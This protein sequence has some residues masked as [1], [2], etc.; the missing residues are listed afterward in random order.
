MIVGSH[1]YL[2]VSI[3]IQTDID[4]GLRIGLQITPAVYRCICHVDICTH[5]TVR[6]NHLVVL[7]IF[8]QGE[9]PSLHTLRVL[10]HLRL[11]AHRLFIG[12]IDKQ[13]DDLRF[14]VTD[15]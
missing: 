13:S 11:I 7:S 10:Q 15:I 3:G 4:G 6:R 9:I 2:F 8:L 1:T 5:H 14:V 12:K